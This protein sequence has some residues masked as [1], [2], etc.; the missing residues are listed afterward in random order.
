MMILGHAVPV[1]PLIAHTTIAGA[2]QGGTSPV[3]DT[4][5][6]TFLVINVGNFFAG[7][8]V[9]VSDSK[10]NTWTALTPSGAGS[11]EAQST[12][13]YAANPTV[14]SGHT[15]SATSVTNSFISA[16]I[17]AFNGVRTT[18]PFDPGI[19]NHATGTATSAKATGSITPSVN[20]CLLI[21]GASNSTGQSNT[22]SIDL[23]FSQPD[24]Y[25]RYQSGINES[26][27]LA[28]FVQPTAAAINPTWTWSGNVGSIGVTIA[29]FRP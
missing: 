2:A 12:L 1:G 4:T 5:G 8:A 7:G 19:E 9:T 16:S 14:G 13:Y 29:S 25:V 28:W 24:P 6:A 10:S 21:A 22:L 15:F 17:A 18:S 3:I 26:S 23:G 11:T 27:G 20:G